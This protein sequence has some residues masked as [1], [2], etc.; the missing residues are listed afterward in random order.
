MDS[1]IV[2]SAVSIILSLILAW[3]IRSKFDTEKK[4]IFFVLLMLAIPVW[5]SFAILEVVFDRYKVL[6]SQLAYI[7][8]VSAP[9][10]WLLF[11]LEYSNG[12]KKIKRWH[13]ALLC[14]IPAIT[15]LLVA[16]NALHR[17]YWTD[18]YPEYIVDNYII[19]KYE[20][21]PWFFINAIYAYIMF[22]A[23][24][25]VF[26]I[27][28]TKTK[29]LKDFFL[30]V[31]GVLTP[32][33]SNIL[34]LTRITQM[35]YAPA[36]LSFSCF[37]FAWSIVGG[38]F[39]RKMAIAKTIHDNID[40]GIVL[41]DEDYKIISINPYAAQILCISE[42]SEGLRAS[43]VIGFWSEIEGRLNERNNEHFEKYFDDCFFGIHLYPIIK[44]NG[45]F[46]W[47]IS[48]FDITSKKRVEEELEE[49]RKAAEAANIAKSNFVAS[50]SHEIRTPL[51]G[52]IGFID[53]L[54]HTKLDKDQHDYLSE[55]KNASDNLL[56]MINNVLDFSKIEASR[57][58]I[59]DI[60]FN[61]HQVIE[62]AISLFTAKAYSK[63]ID[64]HSLI[65]EGVPDIVSGDPGKLR[66]VLNNLVG[67][68][69][70]FTT[71]GDVILS[72]SVES[73]TDNTVTLRFDVSDTGIGIAQDALHRIFDPFSQADNTTTR[74]Y[75]GTGLG[76]SIS[77]KLIEIMG[78]TIH[79]E[80]KENCGTQFYF[81]L[82]FR[83]A[84]YNKKI[85]EIYNKSVLV[86]DK[87]RTSRSIIR[88]YLEEQGLY[89]LE[90]EYFSP[91]LLIKPM[92]K[93]I[94]AVVIDIDEYLKFIGQDNVGM[95]QLHGLKTF[96]AV[97]AIKKSNVKEL[98]YN[99]GFDGFISKPFR[100]AEIMNLFVS[101]DFC[102]QDKPLKVPS[103]INRNDIKKRSILLVEDMEANRKLAIII[104]KK[105]GNDCDIA[106]DGKEACELCIDQKYDMIFMD[107]QMPVMDGYEA[108]RYIK[109][110][111]VNTNTPVIAMTANA[112]KGDMEK[113][114]EAG[115]DDF[116]TKPITIK[117][118]DEVI[119]KWSK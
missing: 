13:L 11:S 92:D 103:E 52:I 117:K 29:I 57:I 114:M 51:N 7:G 88:R 45:L 67:N 37:C 70:K 107:C 36:A 84:L 83:K 3:Q 111:G 26:L 116:I 25:V 5:S 47:I 18:I 71:C 53:V 35:D 50:V 49:R 16:T 9:V 40:E 99:R 81:A 46:G 62:E 109:K 85:T 91:D 31:L 95:P 115:M 64:I 60:N 97:P 112:M 65:Q 15:L 27:H 2:L 58:E 102:E 21:G 44:E 33:I 23:G 87:N 54:S 89:V 78:S 30:I 72:V 74:K 63:A 19:Y 94:S 56:Y 43:D 28:F 79:V 34:Y 69:V 20:R 90:S 39:E 10:F 105:T 22:V 41:I 12:I 118:I 17:L 93:P 32:F 66:Q 77:K 100:K 76:L 106:V 82:T 38:F 98:D 119:N 42:F 4:Y 108:T 61:I 68:A 86:V 14:I 96:I 113:C 101:N 73:Q 75:G 110:N 1:F 48:L 6:F 80:S 55:I 104:I 24:L 59:E 8:I